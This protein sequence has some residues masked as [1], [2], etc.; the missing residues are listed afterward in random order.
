MSRHSNNDR[1]NKIIEFYRT[2]NLR[3][4]GAEFGISHW[5]VSQILQA[6]KTAR[7]EK[8]EWLEPLDCH[9][10]PC[11]EGAAKAMHLADVPPATRAWNRLYRKRRDRYRAMA[12]AALASVKRS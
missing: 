6:H 9:P 12:S 5:R 1:D 8:R 3:Q 4:T 10:D 7:R 11:I 2:H